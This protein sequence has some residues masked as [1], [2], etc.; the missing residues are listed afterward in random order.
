MNK[1]A[2]IFDT[3]SN[4]TSKRQTSKYEN[5]LKVRA[6]RSYLNSMVRVRNLN[7]V[8]TLVESSDESLCRNQLVSRVHK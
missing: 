4:I 7:Q 5:T 2:H 3:L 8:T 6:L 1:A